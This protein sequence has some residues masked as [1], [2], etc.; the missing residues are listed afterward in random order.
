MPIFFKFCL[1]ETA[2]SVI[3]NFFKIILLCLCTAAESRLSGTR[4]ASLSQGRHDIPQPSKTAR[5]KLT[6]SPNYTKRKPKT[7]AEISEAN[8][9]ICRCVSWT[10]LSEFRGVSHLY[11]SRRRTSYFINERLN[12]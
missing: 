9:I 12:Q 1:L 6:I 8:V 11:K 5:H 4:L 2:I 10:I 3:L 7:H